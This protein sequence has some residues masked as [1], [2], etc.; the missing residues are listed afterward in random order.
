MTP[1]TW[2]DSFT[3]RLWGPVIRPHWWYLKGTPYEKR[4][5][6][7]GSFKG[8]SSEPKR[9]KKAQKAK[10]E[11][12]R[13]GEETLV[14]VKESNPPRSSAGPGVAAAVQGGSG[15]LSGPVTKTEPSV[16]AEGDTTASGSRESSGEGRHRRKPNPPRKGDGLGGS[17]LV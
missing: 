9:R 13:P 17:K 6:R 10:T 15:E 12:G 3:A 8:V 16:K 5:K 11:E 2:M 14:R 7:Q 4:R 1:A